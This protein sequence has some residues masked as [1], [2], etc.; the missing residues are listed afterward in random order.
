LT[1]GI[2]LATYPGTD[3][4]ELTVAAFI[5]LTGVSGKVRRVVAGKGLDSLDDMGERAEFAET[6]EG[7]L[8]GD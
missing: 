6:V 2:F 7:F 5:G 3:A 1:L 4:M 8:A